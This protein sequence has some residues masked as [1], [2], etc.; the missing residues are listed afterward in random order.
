MF[1]QT[2]N[3]NGGKEIMRRV[4]AFNDK[5]GDTA[6]VTGLIQAGVAR[7][8]VET[9]ILLVGYPRPWQQRR[10]NF[11]AVRGSTCRSSRSPLSCRI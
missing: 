5:L 8:L 2:I 9:S 7:T 3:D 11:T 10:E 6:E 1:A 4:R